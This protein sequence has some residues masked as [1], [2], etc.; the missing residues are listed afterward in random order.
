MGSSG[1]IGHAE[2]VGLK[3]AWKTVGNIFPSTRQGCED[4]EVYGS[5]AE[6]EAWMDCPTEERAKEEHGMERT[7]EKIGKIK[8]MKEGYSRSFRN[9][10]KSQRKV[11]SRTHHLELHGNQNS[12]QHCQSN[13]EVDTCLRWQLVRETCQQI[14]KLLKRYTGEDAECRKLVS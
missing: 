8:Q 14:V 3:V 1:R 10:R 2:P 11:R 5:S 12:G 9:Q 13:P 4:R 6:E 7:H